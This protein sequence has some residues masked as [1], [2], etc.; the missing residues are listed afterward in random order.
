M[1]A[2]KMGATVLYC[3]HNGTFIADIFKVGNVNV[4]RANGKVTPDNIS[5]PANGA[6][7]HLSDFPNGGFW[8]PD[9]GVFVVPENQVTELEQ[10]AT[11]P[12]KRHH[13]RPIPG[14]RYA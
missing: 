6:T 2:A 1:S 8:R 10:P 12:R 7:H 4:V 5:R 14:R 13:D 11:P 3:G 9:L